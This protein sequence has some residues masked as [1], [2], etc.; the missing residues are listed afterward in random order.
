M[1]PI[2]DAEYDGSDYDDS[3]DRERLAGQ[4]LRVFNAMQAGGWLT[5]E[6]LARATGDPPTSVSAQLR[7][8]RKEKFGGHTVE[9]THLGKGLYQYRLIVRE[10]AAKVQQVLF[11]EE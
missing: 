6:Q 5:L 10:P 1:R 2:P 3:R 11:E 4:T 9:K 8:L 7:H